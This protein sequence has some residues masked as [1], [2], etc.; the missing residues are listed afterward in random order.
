MAT[1]GDYLKLHFIIFLWGFTA[2]IGLL[3]S[4]PAVEM[5]FFRTLLASG[6]MGVLIYFSGGTFKLTSVDFFKVF[7]TGFIV[8]V[9]WL[10]FFYSGRVAN[11]SVSLV[12]FATGAFW[13]AILEPIANGKKINIIEVGLGILVVIGLYIIFSFD[14]Q[15]QLGLTLGILSGLTVAMFAVINSKLVK[16]ISSLTITFY[17]M[18]GAT[19]ATA[20]FL[21]FYK[22]LTAESGELNLNPTLLDWFYI[23]ILALVCSVYAYT[24]SVELMRRIS[25]FVMQL[26]MTLEPVYGIIMAVLIFGEKEKMNTQFYIGTLVVISAVVLYPLLKTKQQ[27]TNSSYNSPDQ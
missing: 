12:G 22:I 26:T 6:G 3:I 7:L 17:E 9:H 27:S 1:A 16:R 10:T 20:L 14:F 21:P 15:Y 11:A 2:V 18:V 13:T 5:V 23:T 19:F 25:A 24:V 8:S 4:I